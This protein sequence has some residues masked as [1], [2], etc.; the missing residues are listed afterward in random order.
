MKNP[1]TALITLSTAA[2]VAG[3]EAHRPAAPR[4]QDDGGGVLELAPDE[5]GDGPDDDARGGGAN[6]PPAAGEQRGGEIGNP[7]KA[8][9]LR[10]RPVRFAPAAASGN[11]GIPIVLTASRVEMS[12]F[13]LDPFVAFGAGLPLG[14]IPASLRRKFIY[15][16]VM[17]NA[18]GTSAFAPYG[19]RKIGALLEREFGRENVVTIHPSR[20]AQFVGARTRVIGI[21]T[22]DPGGQ[23]F[24]SRTLSGIMG[25]QGKPTTMI[26]FEA[27]MA[28]LAS[29]ESTARILVGGVGA[30]QLLQP[31]SGVHNCIDTFVLGESERG[32]VELFRRVFDNSP[33]DRV[34]RMAPPDLDDIP[35]IA[36]PSIYGTV[37]ITRGCGRGCHFCWPTLRKP[38]SFPKEHIL[39]EVRLNAAAGSRMIIL[40][41]DDLFLYHAGPGFRPNR[42]AVADLIRGVADT[43]G[44]EFIQVAHASLPPV[45]LEPAMISEIA[46]VLVERSMWDYRGERCASVEIGLE[47]GSA[48]L[49]RQHMRGKPLPFT[50][51]NWPDIIV[52]A[53]DILNAHRIYPLATL[54]IGL[55][56]ETEE[57]VEAT[58][59]L[60]E[61]LRAAKIFY[62]PL[63]FVSEGGTTL[64]GHEHMDVRG[65]NASRWEILATCW[66]Q[67]IDRWE[68]GC[69]RL[70]GLARRLPSRAGLRTLISLYGIRKALE[71]SGRRRRL[72][73]PRTPPGPI[74]RF[75][76]GEDG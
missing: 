68:P 1:T 45:V 54:V 69:S 61:R 63:L 55:P 35:G 15:P 37:E 75:P 8:P 30:W 65:L 28:Q 5:Q 29:L 74:R 31:A 70:A 2:F 7:G 62:V 46:P 27:L 40:Q 73:R 44:V 3:Q 47:S 13:D 42:A 18:D 52:Q 72:M 49:V 10:G 76:E 43:P 59:N 12:D 32:V 39:A 17:T 26:E 19:L 38:I 6:K 51:E 21:S 66:R 9:R 24:V 50:P 33:L 23:G 11:G 67:N 41:T 53:V 25:L 71:R 16:P 14:F 34:V 58:L 36:Q 56:G 20:L 60:I 4:V 57:D 22:M 64:D 48:R